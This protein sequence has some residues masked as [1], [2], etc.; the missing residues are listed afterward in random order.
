MNNPIISFANVE[1]SLSD[2]TQQIAENFKT[3]RNGLCLAQPVTAKAVLLDACKNSSVNMRCIATIAATV[4]GIGYE[5]KD[6]E[7][8]ESSGVVNF[9]NNLT[10]R[11]GNPMPFAKLLNDWYAD[12][13]MFGESHLEI[14]R[15]DGA[16]INLLLLSAKNV[17]TDLDRTFLAQVIQIGEKSNQFKIFRPYQEY[18]STERDC[19]SLVRQM[20]FDDVY[21]VP[22]YITAIPAITSNRKIS[23]ANIES[24][25]NTIRGSIAIE[26]TGELSDHQQQLIAAAY[27]ALK[28]RKGGQAIIHLPPGV[29]A[30]IRTMGS[31]T[32]DGD[33]LK[34]RE[35]NE[36]EIMGV[37]M[38]P[39]EMYSIIQSGGISSGEKATGAL[40]I[41]KQTVVSPEQEFLSTFINHILK[42]EFTGYNGGFK[43]KELDLT[44][45]LE[46]Q[47]AEQLKASI[48]QT[49]VNLGSLK[50]LNEY[51]ESIQLEPLTNEEFAVIT[52]NN[53]Q[54]NYSQPAF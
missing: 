12:Y 43:L 5:F 30:N 4:A 6:M 14:A 22:A 9:L 16:I 18:T 15:Q 53:I 24:M 50:L 45:S 48:Q 20:A 28:L 39:P 33:Y 27:R 52:A 10:D 1:K 36:L 13:K 44:D 17:Y 3:Y 21:G 31:I 46:D 11:N 37:H 32:V 51:R 19:I 35:K 54:P 47:Q 38:V 34:E 7:N 41:F 23:E 26:L 42:K 29:T 49:Y 8:A 2:N 40:K 25:D